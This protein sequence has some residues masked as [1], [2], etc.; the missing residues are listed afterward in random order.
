VSEPELPP[1]IETGAS[2]SARRVRFRKRPETEVRF[3]G[4]GEERTRR[5][6]LPDEVEPGVTYRDVRV[7]WSTRTKGVV[8]DETD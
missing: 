7:S 3:V 1:E 6:N 4:D 8:R 2:A 5:E